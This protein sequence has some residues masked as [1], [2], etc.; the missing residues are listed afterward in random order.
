MNLFTEEEER[1]IEEQVNIRMKQPPYS[2]VLNS[3]DRF[4]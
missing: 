1:Y 3:M 4:T 2:D